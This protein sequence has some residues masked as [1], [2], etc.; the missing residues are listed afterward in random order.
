MADGRMAPLKR[1]LWASAT[2]KLHL[3][4]LVLGVGLYAATQAFELGGQVLPS[5]TLL[6]GALAYAALVALDVSDPEFIRKHGE[7]LRVESEAAL[8]ALEAAALL[9]PGIREQFKRILLAFQRCRVIYE[10]SGEGLRASLD[11]GLVRSEKLVTVAGRAAKRGDAIT[12]HLGSAT[13]EGLTHDAARLRALS[14]RTADQ[15]ARDG[16]L[17][18][19]AAKEKELET[20]RQLEGLRDR[21]HAQLTLIEA[22]LDG[23]SAKLVKLEASDLTEAL[24][25]NESLE[26]NLRTMTSDVELLESTYE[27]T[28]QELRL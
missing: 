9:D 25:V 27:E 19:A 12:R 8:P 17:Q 15:T 3:G 7:R 1:A 4:V 2:Q 22:S 10:S 24:S 20:Y 6:L 28:M 21:I 11:E 13:P 26:E 14:E 18:A 16:F 5:L 23:F